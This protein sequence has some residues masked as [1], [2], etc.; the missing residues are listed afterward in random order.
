[1][2][3]L[4]LWTCLGVVLAEMF[5]IGS[6]ETDNRLLSLVTNVDSDKHSLSTDLFAK[7]HSPEVTT[8]LGVDLSDDVDKDTV[9]V[10]HD[11]LL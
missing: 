3:F 5:V 1:M 11:G 6:T 7:A 2:T 4:C 9:I 10:L 8:K